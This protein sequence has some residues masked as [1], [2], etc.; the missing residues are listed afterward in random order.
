MNTGYVIYPGRTNTRSSGPQISITTMGRFSLNKTS[1]AIFSDAIV[2]RVI[3]LWDKSSNRIALQKIAKKDKRSVPVRYPTKDGKGGAGFNAKD[4]VE[5]YV[6]F[7]LSS[8]HTYE[9]QWNAEEGLLEFQIE[10]VHL[11]KAKQPLTAIGSAKKAQH[12]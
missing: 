9:A 5:N 11:K 10:A 6:G 3:L 1:T 7:D 8:G 4:F 12:A 2:E